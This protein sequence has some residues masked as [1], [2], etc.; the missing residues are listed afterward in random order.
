MEFLS[1]WGLTKPTPGPN[2]PKM[3][4]VKWAFKSSL[5]FSCSVVSDSATPW[6]AEASLP[7]T[8]SRSLLKLIS[9]ESVMP[10]NC[11][12]LCHPLLLLPSIFPSIK[13]LSN[14]S[15]LCIRW[16]KYW[17]FS[18]SISP[19]NEYSGLISFRMDWFDL[20][21]VQSTLRSLLQYHSS[22]VTKTIATFLG[23]NWW[24]YQFAT[25]DYKW[26]PLKLQFGHSPMGW[27]HCPGPFPYWDSKL[28]LMTDF[29]ALFKSGY[30]SAQFGDVYA[31]IF[32]YC[33]YLSSFNYY[34]LKLSQMTSFVVLLFF[35]P[36][37]FISWSLIT[38]QYCSGFC[39]TLTWISHGFTCVSH[40]E[41]PPTFLP[42]PSLWVFPVH[43]PWALV[44]CIQS[45]LAICFTLDNIHV[46]MLFSDHPTLVFSHRV[47]KSILYICVSFSVLHIGLSL[48]SF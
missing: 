41:P 26:E 33:F 18:F 20:L 6:T 15:G 5:Q 44:S 24:W 46:S 37:I 3:H 19:S 1:P 10:S 47:Q 11:L 22:N 43:Q 7:S 8:N 45:V 21:G 39:H 23:A 36:L 28:L 25:W 35:F 16:P 12:I 34:I 42:I 48:P 2:N 32:L 40:P 13:V 29:P 31:V 17:S 14:E 4:K 38:L 27:T 9:I 30:R